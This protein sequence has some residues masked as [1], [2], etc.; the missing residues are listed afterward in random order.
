MTSAACSNLPTLGVLILQSRDQNDRPRARDD[1]EWD[2]HDS[3]Q[4]RY[5]VHSL[6]E[7][8][9]KV[10]WRPLKIFMLAGLD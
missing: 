5:E 9:F 6:D 4:A 8:D 10:R 1:S 7:L 3:V 2:Q